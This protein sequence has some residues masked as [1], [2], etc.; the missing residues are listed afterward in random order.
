MRPD[1][2]KTRRE[3]AKSTVG[4]AFLVVELFSSCEFYQNGG[5]PQWRLYI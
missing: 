5:A 2:K 3:E 1:R 4:T